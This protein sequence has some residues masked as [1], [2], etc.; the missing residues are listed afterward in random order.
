MFRQQVLVG[1]LLVLAALTAAVALAQE[2]EEPLRPVGAEVGSLIDQLG[3]QEYA[4]RESAEKKLLALGEKAVPALK[5]AAEG[6]ADEHVRFEAQRILSRIGKDTAER[7]GEFPGFREL[8]TEFQRLE[9]RM[10]ELMKRLSE[11]GLLGEDD[12]ERLREGMLGTGGSFQGSVD[13]GDLRMK[14]TRDGDGKVRVEVTRDGKTETYEAES[15]E[16][17]KSAHPDVAE[18]VR[19]YFGD[20]RIS[21]RVLPAPLGE[22]PG[23]RIGLRPG[24]PAPR[25]APLRE[26]DSSPP[27]GFRLGIWLG[28]MSE[29]LRAH[30]GLAEGQGLLVESVV[31]GSLA[32]RLGMQRFDVVLTLNGTKLGGA[33][34]I[35]RT[36]EAVPEGGRVEVV[37]IRKAERT[38]LLGTR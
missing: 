1:G 11:R 12:L 27:E 14:Y 34:D 24:T 32:D 5:K 37:V 2:K 38:T 15:D 25:E 29:P 31:P 6:H 35:R 28:E 8:D 30:L 7:P 10:N 9:E 3:D 16:A 36:L 21:T 18:L 33:E 23:F 17:L 20:V 4:V 22:W 13:T 19:K 26:K